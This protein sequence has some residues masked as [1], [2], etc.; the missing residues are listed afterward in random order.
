MSNT[1]S[2]IAFG[3]FFIA[4]PAFLLCLKCLIDYLIDKKGAYPH[5]ALSVFEDEFVR[6]FFM[7]VLSAV[8]CWV[9]F[10]NR[11]GNFYLASN[12]CNEN[13]GGCNWFLIFQLMIYSVIF[14]LF[15]W[16]FLIAFNF[17]LRSISCVW[18]CC[19]F[20]YK[21]DSEDIAQFRQTIVSYVVVTVFGYASYYCYINYPE[22]F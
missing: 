22:M 20:R 7:S 19:S 12:F 16:G 3:I 2:I 5:I 18:V 21:P 13:A 9:L 11:Y 15:F 1:N 6:L 4:N 14:Q 17:T 8:L 10:E